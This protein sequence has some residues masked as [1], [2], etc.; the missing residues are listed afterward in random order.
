MTDL[1]GSVAEPE[2]SW[3]AALLA[4]REIAPH[5][6]FW[7]A[8]DA[9]PFGVLALLTSSRHDDYARM[10]LEDEPP[11]DQNSRRWSAVQAYEPLYEAV[12]QSMTVGSLE[13]GAA[14]LLEFATEGFAED[15]DV[16]LR[17]ACA[18]LA[19]TA[20]TEVD[21]HSDADAALESRLSELEDVAS[22]SH[23]LLRAW[24]LSVRCQN[25]W[26]AGDAPVEL[27]NSI[28]LEL[29]RVDQSRMPAL[30]TSLGSTLS[31]AECLNE[32]VIAL[33]W[34]AQDHV[35]RLTQDWDARVELV[36]RP[37]PRLALR[38][39]AR[40]SDSLRSRLELTF[41]SRFADSVRREFTF[42]SDS[43]GDR[44]L[45]EALQWHEYIGSTSVGHYR[46]TLGLSRFV[47]GR[48]EHEE[49]LIAEGVRLLRHAGMAKELAF[50]CISLMREGPLRVLR[51]QGEVVVRSRVRA[52]R[53]F[54]VDLVVLK[55]SADLLSDEL[56][57]EALSALM[58][59]R[60]SPPGPRGLAWGHWLGHAEKVWECIDRLAAPSRDVG[61]LVGL[62]S[63]AL[64]VADGD[65]SYADHV[66]SRLIG[67][68]RSDAWS[69]ARLIE[70]AR[71]LLDH[72]DEQGLRQIREALERVTDLHIPDL[73]HGPA[74]A[75]LTLDLA[76]RYVD[77]ML[78]GVEDIPGDVIDALIPFLEHGLVQ[79]RRNAATGRF[80]GVG[81]PIADVALA[82][83][84]TTKRRELWVPLTDLL[85]DQAVQRDDKDAAIARLSR[86]LESLPDD[87]R[88]KLAA[89]RSAL[90]NGGPNFIGTATEPY[91]PGVRLLS[92]IGALDD[93]E[94]LQIVARLMSEGTVQAAQ[95]AAH[96]VLSLSRS[97]AV[98]DWLSTAAMWLSFHNDPLVRSRAGQAL[99]TLR[100]PVERDGRLPRVRALLEEDGVYVPLGV[101]VGLADA[102]PAI[103]SSLVNVLASMASTHP[104]SEIREAAQEALLTHTRDSE[105]TARSED[106]R[107]KRR[108][109]RKRR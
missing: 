31:P 30:T 17:A 63:D 25:R 57:A 86:N 84:L 24:L 29:D 40:T 3:V 93:G 82:F 43:T 59:L 37:V 22:P 32:I 105:T 71:K 13:E 102:S 20:L 103:R 87:Q 39:R 61:P 41:K 85:L 77:R 66:Y 104:S 47:Q 96:T 45:V 69:D 55:Q 91:A 79:V 9:T 10:V 5:P 74:D 92:L 54:D 99:V 34:V 88:A 14:R 70:P 89:G 98:S 78:A 64:Q 106:R 52:G 50:A 56:R 51:D 62:L 16:A 27:A 53:V 1:E 76:A 109:P 15:S 81:V 108:P 21:R 11:N 46:G 28:G 58:L 26:D 19:A 23:A 60:N 44:A 48:D 33:R 42:G 38:T 72:S 65:T 49:W 36:K 80:A 67:R 4:A 8:E 7:S 18:V 68:W 95:E 101:L 2:L 6:N 100:G 90:L 35:V 75:E 83:T 94:A 97:A 12:R 73:E 107:G